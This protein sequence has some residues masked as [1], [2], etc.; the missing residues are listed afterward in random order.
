[1]EQILKDFNIYFD[2]SIPNKLSIGIVPKISQFFE[3]DI[4]MCDL[5][6]QYKSDMQEKINFYIIC[7]MSS[8]MGM[9]ITENKIQAI[10]YNTRKICIPDNISKK[11]QSIGY[12]SC[13]LISHIF[14]KKLKESNM[15]GDIHL[16]PFNSNITY[17]KE[18]KNVKDIDDIDY[19][20][21]NYLNS[22]PLGKGTYIKNALE[23]VNNSVKQFNDNSM[24]LVIIFTDGDFQDFNQSLSTY[25]LLQKSH[26]TEVACVSMGY[27]T[28]IN[29]I[30]KFNRND[31]YYIAD[32][33]S[34]SKDNIL[35]IIPNVFNN[36]LYNI[37]NKNK[38]NHVKTLSIRI[39]EKPQFNRNKYKIQ[40]FKQSSNNDIFLFDENS[41]YIDCDDNTWDGYHFINNIYYPVN[42]NTISNVSN[43]LTSVY[44]LIDIDTFKEI[45]FVD[46]DN[47]VYKVNLNDIKNDSKLTIFLE[48]LHKLKSIKSAYND[49]DNDIFKNIFNLKKRLFHDKNNKDLQTQIFNEIKKINNMFLLHLSK[50]KFFQKYITDTNI[51]SKHEENMKQYALGQIS[52]LFVIINN[53]KNKLFNTRDDTKYNTSTFTRCTSQ[54][55][56]NIQVTNVIQTLPSINDDSTLCKIC[57]C[58]ISDMCNI[59]CGHIVTCGN[60]E[61]MKYMDG[62]GKCI[63][64]RSS[65]SNIINFVKVILDDC[66]YDCVNCKTLENNKKSDYLFEC[67]HVGYCLH[68]TNNNKSFNCHRC[69]KV[70]KILCRMY[71]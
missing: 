26:N 15:S 45:Q 5:I 61:C 49:S 65:N 46:N 56:S 41:S 14:Q 70:V 66:G 6:K 4:P 18:Y 62:I 55:K 20:I 23:Y 40:R 38:Y 28:N 11:R 22:I 8:S 2:K 12:I 34:K 1:M 17:V 21:F 36:L 52:D 53:I 59:F 31:N 71:V 57:T 3:S 37:I 50:I 25:L 43:S 69:K 68:C 13:S 63:V 48:I 58:N 51:N 42:D 67:G 47:F 24:N 29:I 33:I 44:A 27:N 39:N 60:N 32:F 7:D 16:I 9:K 64:C 54:Y 10:T 35:D 30:K 19:D